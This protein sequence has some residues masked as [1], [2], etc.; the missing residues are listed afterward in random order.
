MLQLLYIQQTDDSDNNDE[1]IFI[2]VM[3]SQ[4]WNCN[5]YVFPKCIY[6]FKHTVTY[7]ISEG[8]VP[9]TSNPLHISI[10]G[11]SLGIEKKEIEGPYQAS[12]RSRKYPQILSE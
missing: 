9:P 6:R 3:K 12:M 1:F 10:V 2:H 11:W 5:W 8:A 7:A 4:I